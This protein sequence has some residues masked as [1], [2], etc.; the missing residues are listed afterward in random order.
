M[1]FVLMLI[2]IVRPASVF[3]SSLRSRLSLKERIFLSWM[4]PRGIVAA[5]VAS[6]FAIRLEHESALAVP[7]GPGRRRGDGDG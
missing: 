2:L 3:L 5:A 6:V 7:A 4:A 1:L